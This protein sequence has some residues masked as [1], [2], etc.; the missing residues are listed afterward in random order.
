[1]INRCDNNECVRPLDQNILRADTAMKKATQM[2][3]TIVQF[4]PDLAFVRVQMGEEPASDRAYTMIYNKSYKSVSSMLQTEDI[5]EG[6]DYQFDTQTILPWLEGSY[7]NF[8]YV[9]KLDDIE[10]FIEQ[11]N[12]INTL[13]EYESF[14][15]RYGIRRTN[16]DFWLHADWFNQQH[17]REQP[18]KA[19][20]FDLSRYQNR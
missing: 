1:F 5:A 14:V 20:I 11:Y 10:G 16:E 17:L 18:V 7:P 15:A 9:V 6:R 2:D 13:N 4:L 8:F 12:T 3:G 19:G